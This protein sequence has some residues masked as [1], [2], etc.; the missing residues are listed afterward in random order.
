M[1]Y[2]CKTFVHSR[3]EYSNVK[4]LV[5]FSPRHKKNSLVDYKNKEVEGQI[6]PTM[7]EKKS[8]SVVTTDVSF[9]SPNSNP[10]SPHLELGT[11]RE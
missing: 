7:P 5:W 6:V 9:Q 10:Q 3:K 1:C 8:I 4:L 2:L 11:Q